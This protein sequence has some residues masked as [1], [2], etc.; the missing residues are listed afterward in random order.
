M[1]ITLSVKINKLNGTI[2]LMPEIFK[3]LECI[4]DEYK[5]KFEYNNNFEVNIESTTLTEDELE[6]VFWDFYDYLG[7]ILGYF[8]NII[9]ATSINQKKLANIVE[10]YKTKDCFIRINEQ[11]IIE[12]TEEQFK[13][14]FCEFLKIKAKASLQLD[15]FNIAM[16]E[17][18]HYPEI[19]IINTLQSLQ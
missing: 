9:S 5:I 19:A 3:G 2:V 7:I 4:F 13:K 6:D 10:K 18:N 17:S 14:S 11:Y 16:M 12:M 15:M 8:P 1:N